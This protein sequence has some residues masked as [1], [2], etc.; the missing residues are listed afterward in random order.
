MYITGL[1]PILHSR[2]NCEQTTSKPLAGGLFETANPVTQWPTV[3]F[4]SDTS[5]FFFSL[6]RWTRTASVVYSWL[7]TQR[8][9]VR[10]PAPPDFLSSRGS[11]TGS[12]E[13]GEHN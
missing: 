4:K 10:F 2:Q 5:F 11:A 6:E 13:S 7:Q 1:H 3:A 9:R 8:S 12:T